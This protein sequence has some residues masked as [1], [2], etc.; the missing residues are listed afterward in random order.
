MFLMYYNSDLITV[1]KKWHLSIPLLH[2]K[3]LC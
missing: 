1:P 2:P 3:I